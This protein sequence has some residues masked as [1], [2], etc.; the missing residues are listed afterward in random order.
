MKQLF[1]V[2]LAISVAFL[3]VLAYRALSGLGV[4]ALDPALE[5]WT[6]WVA[7]VFGIV[8]SARVL[9]SGAAFLSKFS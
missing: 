8:V 2:L 1:A 6:K 7:A 9:W 4:P 5:A 3:M